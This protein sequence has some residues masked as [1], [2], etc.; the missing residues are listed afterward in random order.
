MLMTQ[1]LTLTAEEPSGICFYCDGDGLT[2][3]SLYYNIDGDEWQKVQPHQLVELSTGQYMQLWNKS[4]YLSTSSSSLRL[5]SDEGGSYGSMSLSGN[6][7]SLLNWSY[8]C[9]PY[10]FKALFAGSW[11]GNY[12][13]RSVKNLRMPS[14][15]L[16]EYCYCE[17][18]FGQFDVTDWDQLQLP[19]TTPAE[20]CYEGMFN[21][22]DELTVAPVIHLKTLAKKCLRNIFRECDFIT[23]VEF[24][25]TE[26]GNEEDTFEWMTWCGSDGEFYKPRELE[27]I[28][29]DDYSNYSG[30]R[31][32][33]GWTVIDF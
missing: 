7:M 20:G 15:A 25:F 18:F 32:P 33:L 16:A 3:D 2:L 11:P 29:D 6:I 10:C 19:A 31:I 17:M 23:R 30:C 8:S 12:L 22:C 26:W 27:T 14:M 1:P 28:F 4:N 13:L 21:N 24:H 5:M 9:T